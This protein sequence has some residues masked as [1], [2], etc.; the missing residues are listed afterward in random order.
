MWDYVS[1]Y[2]PTFI[3]AV[4]SQEFNA[5]EQKI[6]WVRRNFGEECRVITVE[7]T[8][9]KYRYVQPNFIL[10]D[11]QTRALESW[12]E[13]GGIGILHIDA[14]STIQEIEKFISVFI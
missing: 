2:N 8:K 12:I 10:I 5:G 9:E 1:G 7:R 14:K 11:D 3:T 4:G 13:Y 6:N